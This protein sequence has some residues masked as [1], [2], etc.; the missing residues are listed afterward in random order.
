MALV[1]GSVTVDDEGVATGSG[2]ALELYQ[3]KVD[4]DEAYR[5]SMGAPALPLAVLVLQLRYYALAATH[6]AA[7]MLAYLIAHTDVSVTIHSGDAALQRLPT[8]ATAGADTIGPSAP[9]SLAG[10]IS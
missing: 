4:T 2:L 9:H 10:G 5:V 6:D 8:P 1:A 7:R 3:A